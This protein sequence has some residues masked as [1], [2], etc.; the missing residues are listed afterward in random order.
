M[1]F[2]LHVTKSPTSNALVSVAPSLLGD[3]LDVYMTKH[4]CEPI[5]GLLPWTGTAAALGR[6][7][8]STN[9]TKLSVSLTQ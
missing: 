6:S 9:I 7:S 8:V 3:G 5:L 1:L 4:I 2:S